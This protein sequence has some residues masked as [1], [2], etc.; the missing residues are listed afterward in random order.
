MKTTDQKYV[1]RVKWADGHHPDDRDNL[2]DAQ[3]GVGTPHEHDDYKRPPPTGEHAG[4]HRYGKMISG[5]PVVIAKELREI[6]GTT[7]RDEGDKAAN[8]GATRSPAA[9][10]YFAELAQ[11]TSPLLKQHS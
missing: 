8:I 10:E 4:L 11:H 1:L 6:I 9:V 5:E 7:I 3:I 2:T